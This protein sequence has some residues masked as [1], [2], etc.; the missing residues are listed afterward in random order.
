MIQQAI[1]SPRLK[2]R[3]LAGFALSGRLVLLLRDFVWGLV[4]GRMF[5]ID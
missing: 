5:K 1:E 2:A 3:Y 4:L